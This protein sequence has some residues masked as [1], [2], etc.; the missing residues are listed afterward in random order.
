MKIL[1]TGGCGFIGSSFVNYVNSYHPNFEIIVVDKLTYAA[2]EKLIP[3]SIKLVKKDICELTI[4]DVGNF[5]YCVNFAAESHVD[6]SIKD[7]SPFVKTNIV[8]TY[9][10]LELSKKCT[11]FRKYVQISTDEVYGD[12][13]ELQKTKSIETDTLHPSSYYS[14]T[15]SA[16]DQLILAATHTYK[17]PTLI[18]RTCNN[19]GKNQNKEKFLPKVMNCILNGDTIPVYG[20]GRQTREWIWVEDNVRMIFQLMNDDKTGIWNIGSGDI[21]KNIDIL[22]FISKT[23][24]ND[25]NYKF[26]TD[27]LG[28]DRRY[29]LDTTKFN[30]EYST[31]SFV[32]KKLSEFITEELPLL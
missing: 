6:N 9:N 22:N 28:H 12:L 16:A 13:D 26:V 18:T 10:M 8:G 20:D 15:K 25:V 24:G 27:R 5:N 1:V 31:H 17:L 3:S 30:N 23:T 14:A 2:D 29:T 7:G 21:W 19:F 4:D 11:N 32:T